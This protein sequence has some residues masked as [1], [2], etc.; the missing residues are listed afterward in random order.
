MNKIP[1]LLSALVLGGFAIAGV[2]L[3]ALA[4]ERLEARIAASQR[5]AIQR[6]LAAILPAGLGDN[7]PLADRIEVSDRARLG[8]DR[9]PV[10]RVRRGGEPV[11]LILSPVVPDGYAGPIDLLVSVLR[12]GSVGGVRVLSHRET[13]GLGDG[14]EEAKSDWVLGFRGKSLHDPGEDAWAVRRDGGAFDQFTGATV[15]PR[16]I[17]G[18]VKSTLLYVRE[19]GEGLYREA[20]IPRPAPPAPRGPS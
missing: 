19:R 8:S 6:K 1:I 20:P 16:A 18:A 12:D 13:P 7:D 5:L 3:V 2:G 4:H 9:T 15:T 17:V 11:A 10:Y 14:I